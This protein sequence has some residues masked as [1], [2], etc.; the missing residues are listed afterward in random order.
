M[1]TEINQARQPSWLRTILIGRH[2]RRTLIRI[3]VTVVTFVLLRAFVVLPIRV[4]GPSMLPTYNA[5]R[6]NFIN[7]L[8]YL[9][10]EP[11][12]GDVVAIRLAGESV[13]FMKR[14][15]GLPGETVAFSNGRLLI[16]G[17][18]L[19]EPYV[20]F[21][22]NWNFVPDSSKLGDDEYYVVGDNRSMPHTDHTQGAAKRERIVGKVL[23]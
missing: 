23:L 10:H 11:R 9:G 7:R 18:S 22:C 20:K 5:G 15:I 19:E 21:K 6:V 14:V 13:M 2:P 17:R 4:S 3:V 16:N 12:R 8:A 1:Q